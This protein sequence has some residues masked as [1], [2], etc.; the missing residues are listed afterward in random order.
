M[1]AVELEGKV[2][3]S[4]ATAEPK[5]ASQGAEKAAFESIKT[6]LEGSSALGGDDNVRTDMSLLESGI[7]DS[8]GILQLVTF[9]SDEFG[10]EVTDDDFVA[11]NFETVGSL[12]QFVARKQ[13][14]AAA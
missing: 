13:A 14:D 7:L 5:C 3:M 11:E 8:L 4:T 2:A 1:R 9:L 10:I 6:F 12:A